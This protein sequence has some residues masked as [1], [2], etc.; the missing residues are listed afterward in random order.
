[1]ETVKGFK[2]YTGEEARKRAEIRKIIVDTFEKYN[3]EP[4]ET[5]IVEYKEFVQ[6]ENKQDEAVS[7]I[8]KLK[9]KGERELALRYEFTFQLKRLMQ[10]KKLP[11][12]RYQIGEVFRDEPVTSNRFRQFVQCDVDV[13]GSKIRDEVEILSISKEI[14]NRLGIKFV[15]YF[16]NRKLLNEILEEQGITG[17]DKIDIIKEIDKFDK[18]P[19]KEVRENM[20]K[21]NAEKIIDVLKKPESYFS[22]Y[23]SYKELKEF[24]EYLELY[25]V[26]ARFSPSLSRGL[27]YY[28]GTVF[29][30]KTDKMNDKSKISLAS[31]SSSVTWMKE[32]I[33]G[34]GSYEFNGVQCT[35]ISFGLDRLS[36]LA[37]F[38]FT[39]NSVLI[40]SLNEDKQAIKIAD[41]LRERGDA[42]S[43]FYGKPSKALE[44]ANSWNIKQVIFV[45]AEEV[46]TKKF[47]VKDMITGKEKTLTLEKRTK[48]NIVVQRK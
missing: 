22:K 47:K 39:K 11:Y 28:N 44:Y 8:F 32:T 38:N 6:G 48:K 45:G 27:S 40:V 23:N 30:I 9:D 31:N 1:M 26:E 16:N 36:M 25:N 13:V 2:D 18:L 20:K 3:F 7:D 10:N 15:I 12:R 37:D 5:P 4:A 17:K 29:E 34:G 19:E 24:E 14:L 33:C 35:G 42:V 41:M 21:Y 46:K 43:I